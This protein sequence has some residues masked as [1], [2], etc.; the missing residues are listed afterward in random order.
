MGDL[1]VG[2]REELLR[3]LGDHGGKGARA[4]E[5]AIRRGIVDGYPF[6]VPLVTEVSD[7]AARKLGAHQAKALLRAPGPYECR[8]RAAPHQD[9]F[10]VLDAV[11][12][13]VGGLALPACM[14]V[15]V[16]RVSRLETRDGRASPVTV[17]PVTFVCGGV[18]IARYVVA[19]GV[20]S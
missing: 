1:S 10:A 17:I 2:E 7:L 19:E 15:V 6:V 18:T 3:Y 12:G 14:E 5:A 20:K 4:R 13:L 11:R 8:E 9:A 16:G